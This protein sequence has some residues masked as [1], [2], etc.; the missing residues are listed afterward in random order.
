MVN[1]LAID[2]SPREFAPS[3]YPIARTRL[4]HRMRWGNSATYR[5]ARQRL[6]VIEL[7]V[8]AG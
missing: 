3:G 6:D 1:F 7:R 2:F 8:N 4:Y 5:R